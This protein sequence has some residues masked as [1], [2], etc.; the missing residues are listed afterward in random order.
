MVAARPEGPPEGGGVGESRPV[1]EGSRGRPGRHRHKAMTGPGKEGRTEGR[2]GNRREPRH[3]S[4]QQERP[5]TIGVRENTEQGPEVED[6][7]S[8]EKRRSE[9]IFQRRAPQHIM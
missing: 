2:M 9:V 6:G 4:F 7:R 8:R 5:H 1:K 3:P